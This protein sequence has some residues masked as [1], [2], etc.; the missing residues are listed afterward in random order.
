MGYITI[1]SAFST[2][3]AQK[4]DA[5]SY[6]APL[7]LTPETLVV[8]PHLQPPPSMTGRIEGTTSTAGGASGRA[9]D[10]IDVLVC[11]GRRWIPR[12]SAENLQEDAAHP[13]LM[14][15]VTM[16]TVRV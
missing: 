8:A 4:A 13:D 12:P 9:Y 1:K 7:P 11:D 16:A 15:V 10:G 14:A 3:S 5:T 2:D 6:A